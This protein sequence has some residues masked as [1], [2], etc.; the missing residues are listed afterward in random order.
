MPELRDV[1]LVQV[2]L[3]VHARTVQWHEDLMREFTLIDIS[4][5][6]NAAAEE[7]G[8]DVPARLLALVAELRSEYAPFTDPTTQELEHARRRGEIATDVTYTVPTTVGPVAQRFNELLDEADGFCR[9]GDLLTLAAS[10]E[11]ASF[12]RWFLGEFTR[13]LGGA[14]P[15]PWPARSGS[16]GQPGG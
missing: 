9:S 15:T 8:A 3:D 4:E 16:G 13:Q 14:Q 12:R 10:P 11:L 7:D 5:S 2:P 6:Q 1:R